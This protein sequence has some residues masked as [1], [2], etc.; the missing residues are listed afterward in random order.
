LIQAYRL[1]FTHSITTAFRPRGVAGR[2]NSKGVVV[3]YTAEHPALAALE[4]LTSWDDYETF[5]NY[6]LY[7]CEFGEDEVVDALEDVYVSGMD[8]VDKSATQKFGDRWVESRE[9]VIL[10]VPSVVVPASLNYVLN[11]DHPDFDRVIKREN[12]GP[13]KFDERILELINRAK[14]DR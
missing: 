9:S 12:L 13:F 3:V 1:A 7:R 4:M 14:P 8:P 2:W 11:P 10:R 6:H 5:N